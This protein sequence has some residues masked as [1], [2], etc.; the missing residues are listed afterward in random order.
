MTSKVSTNR[1]VTVIQIVGRLLSNIL[2]PASL[3][4]QLSLGVPLYLFYTVV[5]LLKSAIQHDDC[6][7]PNSQGLHKT[8][9]IRT[10]TLGWSKE[11]HSNKC[12]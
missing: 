1:L 2:I 4:S 9:T 12:D 7:T 11:S 5:H 10:V 8:A 6:R 3:R